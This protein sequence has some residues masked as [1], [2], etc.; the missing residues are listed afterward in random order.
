MALHFFKSLSSAEEQLKNEINE[1]NSFMFEAPKYEIF[2]AGDSHLSAAVI[3]QNMFFAKHNQR[4]V[5]VSQK[6]KSCIPFSGGTS[7]IRKCA[8]CYMTFPL[9]IISQPKDT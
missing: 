5:F 7:G 9:Y 1:E 3:Q 2:R 4:E 6:E 8:F